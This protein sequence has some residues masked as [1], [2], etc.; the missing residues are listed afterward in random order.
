VDRIFR[1]LEM[2]TIFTTDICVMYYRI[3]LYLLCYHISMFGR[4]NSDEACWRCISLRICLTLH[5][6]LFALLDLRIYR[7]VWNSCVIFFVL[8]QT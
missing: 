7:H 3:Q 4:R 2:M 8:F 6:K 1:N 5:V